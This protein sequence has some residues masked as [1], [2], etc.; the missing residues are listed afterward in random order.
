MNLCDKQQA[1]APTRQLKGQGEGLCK[2][3]P[4]SID[5]FGSGLVCEHVAGVGVSLM[6]AGL[7]AGGMLLAVTPTLVH[8]SAAELGFL[9]AP[10]SSA[11]VQ[12]A[13]PQHQCFCAGPA[14]TSWCLLQ[15]C[16]SRLRARTGQC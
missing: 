5:N 12:P 2:G 11:C 10:P 1:S 7:P 14:V 3:T 15:R 4:A 13:L 8:G 16:V 9:S 6:Q